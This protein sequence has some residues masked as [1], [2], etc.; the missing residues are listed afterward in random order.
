MSSFFCEAHGAVLGFD[1]SVCDGFCE[2]FFVR[3]CIGNRDAFVEAEAEHDAF[4]A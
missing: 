1:P 3:V 4:E 2:A